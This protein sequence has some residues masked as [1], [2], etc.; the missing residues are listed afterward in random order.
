[1]NVGDAKGKIVTDLIAEVKPETMVELGGYSGYSAVLFGDAVRRNGGKRYLSLEMNPEFAA[2]S[3]SL[4]DLAGLSD[5]VKVHVGRSDHSIRR[6]HASGEL[7]KVELMFLDHHKP[8]YKADLKLCESLGLVTPGS[9]IAADNVIYPGSPVYLEYV[10]SSVEKKRQDAASAQAGKNADQNGNS[11]GLRSKYSKGIGKDEPA[12]D[13]AGNPNLIYETKLVNSFE[14]SGEPVS[15]FIPVLLR[16][17]A[18]NCL[19]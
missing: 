1:M 14:P 4:V 17:S 15:F 8:L 19:I 11:E 13:L 16:A 6:L 12:V 9:V 3:R 18:D 5:V 10:R 2:V 7:K